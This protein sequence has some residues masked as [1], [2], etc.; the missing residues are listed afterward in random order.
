MNRKISQE[1]ANLIDVQN[2]NKNGLTK[3]NYL[4]KLDE[5]IADIYN[6]KNFFENTDI[7]SDEYV[8]FMTNSSYFTPSKNPLCSAQ[9]ILYLNYKI[10]NKEYYYDL[11][12][13]DD[14]F[15]NYPDVAFAEYTFLKDFENKDIK[16][17]LYKKDN[18]INYPIISMFYRNKL[19]NEFKDLFDKM[20][21]D[22]NYKKE[23]LLKSLDIL[24]DEA[25]EYLIFSKDNYNAYLNRCKDNE[26]KDFKNLII[27]K[28]KNYKGT[29]INKK[30]IP[31][32][33]F[34]NLM[35]L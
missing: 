25:Y 33:I 22:S 24:N 17:F 23:M 20:F 7:K 13:D 14:P 1:L 12:Y 4:F 2:Y 27:S 29:F 34:F 21:L 30:D 16:I 18:I 9:Y 11:M 28:L 35:T 32:D 26:K 15:N 8:E 5:Y 10:D 3:T 6:H 31:S 19:L